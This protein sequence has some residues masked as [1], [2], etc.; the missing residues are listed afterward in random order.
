VLHGDGEVVLVDCMNETK[1]GVSVE[2][3]W[4]VRAQ[5]GISSQNVKT[6]CNM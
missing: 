1:C 2:W 5:S 3:L 6:K 4:G